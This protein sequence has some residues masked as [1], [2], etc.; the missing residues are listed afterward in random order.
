MK[1]ILV[2]SLALKAAR[3]LIGIMLLAGFVSLSQPRA[4]Y[5]AGITVTS[6]AD[7]SFTR[8]CSLREAIY[9]ANMDLRRDNC[10]A[11]SGADT[12][13]LGRGT[14]VLNGNPGD[15]QGLSGDF[16]ITAGTLTIVGAGVGATIIDG[17]YIDRVFDIHPGA[18]LTISK[19]TIRQG[20]ADIYGGGV[21]NR[22]TLTIINSEFLKNGAGTGAGISNEGR[23]EVYQ[24]TFNANTGPN[25][26]GI[27]N[28]PGGTAI[29]ETSTFMGQHGVHGGAILNQG[30]LILS[31]STLSGNQADN[32]GA[33]IFNAAGGNAQ[34]SFSTIVFNNG[35]DNNHGHGIANI[36]GS[37][38][39]A[40]TILAGN[41]NDC[42]GVL[43]SK[44]FNLIESPFCTGSSPIGKDIW[45]VDPMLGPLQNN[46]GSTL[47][48]APLQGSPVID[49]GSL[50]LM[51]TLTKDQR[52]ADRPI[53]GNGDG[54]GLY[55]IGAVEFNPLQRTP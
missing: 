39:I 46:G 24:S 8:N 37:A 10:A 55:D 3:L 27:A 41:S 16:D 7:D 4:A 18:T 22:G 49:A 12:I 29:I 44:N 28:L 32:I 40:H 51:H 45:Y 25:G 23:V 26:A 48:H 1:R 35:L 53:D 43:G 6:T 21:R 34:V 15:D 20:G 14:Y 38:T 52:G 30:L 36:S 54:V 42:E 9:A 33:G 47:T 50:A 17:Q 13:T 11:G 2:T 19:V 5:A 31:N